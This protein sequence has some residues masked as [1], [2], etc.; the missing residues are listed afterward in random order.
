MKRK[1]IKLLIS[2]EIASSNFTFSG[3]SY[4]VKFTNMRAQIIE[5]WRS[6][7]Y[8]IQTSS[9][10]LGSMGSLAEGVQSLIS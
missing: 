4:F 8:N 5:I 3:N 6:V 7:L 10:S 1:N 2:N 9:L